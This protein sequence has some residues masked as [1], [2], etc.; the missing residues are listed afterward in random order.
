[1][2]IYK[3]LAELNPVNDMPTET[4]PEGNQDSYKQKGVQH[5][6]PLTAK[7]QIKEYN[8]QWEYTQNAL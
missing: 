2:G 7:K 1:M 4:H 6:Y 5:L 3:A 8:R